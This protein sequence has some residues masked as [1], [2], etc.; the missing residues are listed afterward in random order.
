ML[1]ETGP[2]PICRLRPGRSFIPVDNQMRSNVPH[3]FAIG[4]STVILKVSLSF[5][6]YEDELIEFF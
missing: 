5:W 2:L 4:D 1:L 6:L 3:M